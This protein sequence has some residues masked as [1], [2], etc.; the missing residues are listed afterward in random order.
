MVDYP[1]AS[2]INSCL[3]LGSANFRVRGRR[4]SNTPL[5]LAAR[6][7]IATESVPACGLGRNRG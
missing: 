7:L 1:R 3:D 6:V 2:F 5:M 4:L